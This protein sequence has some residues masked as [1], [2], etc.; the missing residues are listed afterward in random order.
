MQAFDSSQGHSVCS[1][2]PAGE[3][4]DDTED[5]INIEL[6]YSRNRLLKIEITVRSSG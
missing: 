1:A 4:I 3:Y 5:L 6:D 2:L